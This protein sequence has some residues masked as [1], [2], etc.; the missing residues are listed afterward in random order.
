MILIT[1]HLFRF[2]FAKL[3]KVYSLLLHYNVLNYT[4]RV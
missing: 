2:V 3:V 4:V 1:Y